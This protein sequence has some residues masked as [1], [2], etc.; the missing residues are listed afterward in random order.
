M[1]NPSPVGMEKL[2]CAT[3]S[4]AQGQEPF[5][6]YS[7][8]IFDEVRERGEKAGGAS[9]DFDSFGALWEVAKMVTEREAKIRTLEKEKGEM[10]E[11]IQMG[12]QCG[13]D[14]S[15]LCN[16]CIFLSQLP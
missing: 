11:F 6:W 16:S 8:A 1:N 12:C 13:T 5:F 2:S 14:K 10:R 4:P 7:E 15:Y 9:Y 3:N